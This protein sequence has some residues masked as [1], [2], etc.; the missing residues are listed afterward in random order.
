MKTSRFFDDEENNYD[1]II[2]SLAGLKRLG[3][4]DHVTEELD[5]AIK[6]QMRNNKTTFLE[7]VLNQELGE[8]FRRDAM[9][10]PT[11]VAGVDLSDM[12]AE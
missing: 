3:L 12:A 5:K 10:K 2:L 1:A 7:V 4:L 11:Q 9:K 8:P 6:E